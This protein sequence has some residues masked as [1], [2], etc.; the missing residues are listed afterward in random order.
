[1]G[2]K[3]VATVPLPQA[4]GDD[5]WPEGRDLYPEELEVLHR[6]RVP[7]SAG[8]LTAYANC[9]NKA[10]ACR[11]V[12]RTTA[13]VI[14]WKQSD[15]AFADLWETLQA[16]RLEHWRDYA[17]KKAR[18]GFHKRLYDADGNIKATEIR[19]DPS[20]LKAVM[21][22]IDPEWRQDGGSDIQITIVRVAE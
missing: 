17:Q 11:A 2:T 3:A 19:E 7:S 12:D 8:F 5:G 1:M 6:V 9:W 22:S 21:G 10:Q 13:C 20:H 18:H 14:K 16:E 4:P 15:S